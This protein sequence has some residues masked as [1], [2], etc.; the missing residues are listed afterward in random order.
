[1]H[2][3]TDVVYAPK[4]DENED[5][6]VNMCFIWQDKIPWNKQLSKESVYPLSYNQL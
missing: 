3:P 6:K 1:M 2:A 4:I 5:S